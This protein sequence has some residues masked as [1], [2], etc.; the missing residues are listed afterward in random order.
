MGLAFVRQTSV[1]HPIQQLVTDS[2]IVGLEL[3]EEDGLG[4]ADAAERGV[5]DVA[6]GGADTRS[7]NRFHRLRLVLPLRLHIPERRSL[8]DSNSIFSVNKAKP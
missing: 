3:D 7:R 5:A 6:V 8:S 2:D 1:R 4:V